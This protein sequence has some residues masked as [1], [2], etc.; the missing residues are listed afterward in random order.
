MPPLPPYVTNDAPAPAQS[1]PHDMQPLPPSNMPPPPNRGWEY[2]LAAKPA[3]TGG[4]ARTEGTGRSGGREAR[5][6]RGQKA[7][8][9]GALSLERALGENNPPT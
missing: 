1:L 3:A 6:A 5:M 7:V 8:T 4:G 2:P 9:R